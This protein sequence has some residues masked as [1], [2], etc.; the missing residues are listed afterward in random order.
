MDKILPVR[1]ENKLA[2]SLLLRCL[3]LLNKR[4]RILTFAVI[5][6]QIFFALLDL[7]GV[8]I[9]GLI[10]SLAVAGVSGNKPGNRVYEFLKLLRIQE[11]SLQLQVTVLG[12]IAAIFL[13]T[14]SILTLFFN[15]KSAY[16]L[17]RRG[18][19][20]SRN[21]IEKI[22]GQD[23]LRIH[24]RSLMETINIVTNGVTTITVGVLGTLIFLISDVSLLIILGIG[25]FV[26]DTVIAF[27]TLILF[28]TIAIVLYQLLHRKIK[29]LGE[30]QNK[31][32]V[33][34]NERIGEVVSSFREIFVRDRRY[35]YANEIGDLRLSLADAVAESNYLPNVSKYA[36]EITLVFG[37]LGIAGFQFLT[38]PAGHAV[39][40]LS[41]FLVSSTRIAPA[42]LRVQQGLLNIKSAFGIASPTLVVISELANQPNLEKEN[43]ST[44]FKHSNFIPSINLRNI[45]FRYP[46]STI[47]AVDNVSLA[48]KPGESVALVGPS[49]SGKTTLI[50]IMLGLISPDI[51]ECEI[52]GNSPKEAIKKWPGSIAY[53]PQDIVINNGTIATN[54]AMGYMI[55]E[56]EESFIW[57]ALEVAQLEKFVKS[58]PNGIHTNVGDRGKSM[59]GGQRQ[60]LGIARA[61]FTNPKL[62]VMDEATS[63]LDG[64]T[65]AAITESIQS[66][67]GV[68]TV[69]TIAHRL[70]TV[71]NSDVVIY[72][73]CGKLVGYG[74]FEQLR[75]LV[76]NFDKS[77]KLMGL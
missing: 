52:S 43:S 76:P 23:L 5:N 27:S 77:A 3:K 72:L 16:F 42:V 46:T 75:N 20:I 47:K 32:V 36:I 67:K 2:D 45:S 1:I 22:L 4:D 9:V 74:S 68:V 30:I 25:L 44:D 31:L 17:S 59:S 13:S 50:D 8:I 29:K 34:G 18:A 73:D 38:Q 41:I 63:S 54:I 66:L 70:S 21:L 37:A 62:L 12:L 49:G 48:I 53:V 40:V 56:L 39:A 60:R 28:S 10:G 57:K 61:L 24:E 26:V 55:N 71:K 69:V 14:K 35:F 15:R 64:E 7:I 11:N 33:S 6:L 51:G 65:E 58:L 19:L